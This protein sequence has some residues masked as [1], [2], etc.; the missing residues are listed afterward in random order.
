MQRMPMSRLIPAGCLDLSKLRFGTTAWSY[1]DPSSKNISDFEDTVKEIRKLNFPDVSGAERY[2]EVLSVLPLII[3][4]K[5]SEPRPAVMNVIANDNNLRINVTG[6]IPNIPGAASLYSLDANERKIAVDLVKRGIDHAS[7]FVR[8]GYA[9][10]AGPL[11]GVHE[12]FPEKIPSAVEIRDMEDYFVDIVG[13]KIAPYAEERNVKISFEP[14]NHDEML[15]IVRPGKTALELIRRINHPNIG[16]NLDT[17]HYA[18]E[19]E[20][21]CIDSIVEAVKSGKAFNL[22]LCEHNRGQFGTGDVG[23]RVR[24]LFAGVVSAIPNGSV[25]Y[26]GPENFYSGLQRPL[27]IWR[28]DKEDAKQVV[29]NASDYIT[30]KLSN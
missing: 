17:T 28:P 10:L 21:P 14:L 12:S 1:Y 22:H 6:F 29:R 4:G 20:G 24:E 11:Q 9:I 26:T 25:L 15:S 16:L 18:Q 13:D 19:A 3:S 2:I 7:D 23:Y 8:N 27:R 30:E 5:V